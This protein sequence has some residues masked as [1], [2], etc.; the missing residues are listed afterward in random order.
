MELYLYDINP[1]F[2][3]PADKSPWIKYKYGMYGLQKE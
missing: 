3:I 1:A 2:G